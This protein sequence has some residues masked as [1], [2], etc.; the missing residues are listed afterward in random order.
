MF[1]ELSPKILG[2]FSYMGN[3]SRPQLPGVQALI[4][5]GYLTSDELYGPAEH[6][7]THKEALYHILQRLRPEVRILPHSLRYMIVMGPI[8]P[9]L[10]QQE[11]EA[12]RTSQNRINIFTNKT[13]SNISKNHWDLLRMPHTLRKFIQSR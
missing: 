9:S 2:D 3:R 1:I 7:L 11:R 4:V 5:M 8:N 12:Q 6:R 13:L 10:I